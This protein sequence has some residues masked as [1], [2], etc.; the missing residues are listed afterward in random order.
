L[1]AAKA[2]IYK[3]S[4]FPRSCESLKNPKNSAI[5]YIESEE[6]KNLP[7][8]IKIMGGDRR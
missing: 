7:P 5:I 6:R 1:T 2:G 8:K 3:M 4:N